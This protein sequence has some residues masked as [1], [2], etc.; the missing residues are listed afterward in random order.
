MWWQLV[1]DYPNNQESALDE[2]LQINPWI[3]CC[4]TLNYVAS[5]FV[6]ISIVML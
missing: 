2:R 4:V 1:I 6:T 5:K 3:Y